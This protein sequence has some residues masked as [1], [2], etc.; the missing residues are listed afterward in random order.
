MK[1]RRVASWL[2]PFLV[3]GALA[4]CQQPSGDAGSGDEAA[5][6]APDS[7]PGLSIADGKLVLNA[8][9]GRPAAAYF[10]VTNNGEDNTEI[11]GA[12]IEGAERSEMHETR[13]GTMS[14]V[15]AL[16]I[17]AGETIAFEPGGKHVMA[18]GVMGALGPGEESEITL[19]FAGGDKVSAP[20][21]VEKM[22]AAMET[23]DHGDSH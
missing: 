15:D 10:T 13:G 7:K 20:L 9:E 22:G 18:F 2:L 11:V 12:Y 5:E 3:T 8:V 1:N 21:A 19:T 17:A 23:M 16:P 4:A 14:Q 6:A